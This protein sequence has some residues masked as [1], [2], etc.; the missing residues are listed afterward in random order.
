MEGGYLINIQIGLHDI[1]P[2]LVQVELYAEKTAHSAIE[3]IAMKCLTTINNGK[4]LI[5]Q[6]LVI[7]TRSAGDYSARIIPKYEDVSVPLEDN[8]IRWQ[9]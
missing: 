5:Y 8:L 3:R 1:D 2:A 4:E 6:A 7:T 9:R